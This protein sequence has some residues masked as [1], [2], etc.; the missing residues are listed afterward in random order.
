MERR[1]PADF[2][3]H[4]QL[5]QGVV[6]SLPQRREG[7][8]RFDLVVEQTETRTLA[9]G[10]VA[11]VSWRDVETCPRAG[12]RWQLELRLRPP[13]GTL[14]PGGF[15]YETWLYQSGIS[16]LGSVRRSPDNRL[17]DAHARGYAWL[18]LRQT[19]QDRLDEALAG[20]THAGIL[21]A[22]TLGERGSLP[23]ETWQLY[24]TTGIN[25]LLAISGMNIALVAGLVQYPLA[26]LWRQAPRLCL[27]WPAPRAAALGG[28]LVAV[29]YAYIAGFGIPVQRALIMLACVQGAL[30]GGRVV[31]ARQ[32]LALALLTVMIYDTRSVLAS[33][34]W[35]SF[36]AMV[37]LHY[38]SAGLVG[39]ARHWQVWTR[40]QTA[41]AVGLLPMTIGLFQRWSLVAPLANLIAIPWIGLWVTPLALCGVIAVG[42]SPTV[43]GPLLRLAESSVAGFDYALRPLA[44]LPHAQL[45]LATP[46][47][48]LWPALLGAAMLLAPRGVPARWLG[49]ILM[50]P[51]AIP[52]VAEVPSGGFTLQ[53]LDVGQGLS[54][55]VRTTHHTL[56]F[57]TGARYSEAFDMGEAVLL[58]ALRSAHVKQVDR[59]ILSHGD[60]DHVGG[61]V[62]LLRNMRVLSILGAAPPIEPHAPVAPCR[63]GDAWQW[64]GVDFRILHPAARPLGSSNDGS[65]VLRVSDGMHSVLLTGDIERPA[66]RALVERWQSAL[67]SEVLV[68]PHHGSHTS[69][70]PTLLDAVQP[71]LVLVPA[72]YHNRYGHP[73]RDVLE[74]Y[75]VR[76]LPV[77]ISHRTGG[78]MVHF[79]G[80]EIRLQAHRERQA[81]YWHSQPDPPPVPVR[82]PQANRL[83]CRTIQN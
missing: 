61:A 22:L 83:S 73:H 49:L 40:L 25:H 1:L 69:S 53:L 62:S 67:R 28:L 26:W 75:R 9:P 60:N 34:F 17:I 14:N 82:A 46:D 59:L 10:H 4:P 81:R 47:W 2:P 54:A 71:C 78:L 42:I 72:G 70:S 51:L 21:S 6:V 45:R 74:R 43:G 16:S 48:A 32:T 66:E 52:H 44:G 20:R 8:C 23:S 24:L 31:R 38:A 63:A 80:A 50:L 41:A 77:L 33:S 15:D 19:L 76:Q 7:S 56:V 12:Q 11:R 36:L 3:D 79:E 68:A 58:P 27:R 65:C 57:D 37:L 29:L 64:D 13:Y 30:L 55:V 35:L 18:R 39:H 5:V